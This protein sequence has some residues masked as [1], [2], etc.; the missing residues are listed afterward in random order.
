[1]IRNS[2][3]L[4]LALTFVLT[5]MAFP[6]SVYK[7]PK[8][9]VDQGCVNQGNDRRIGA[10]VICWLQGHL[11]WKSTEKP[12]M[13]ILGDPDGRNL[14]LAWPPYVVYNSPQKDGSWRMFRMGIRYDRTWK[15]YIFP[16]AAAKC[17]DH[18]LTY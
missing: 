2:V 8:K 3:M 7:P 6:C 1:M 4:L 15:G 13:L 16:T 17:L 18:P 9:R 12:D 10:P 5:T 14:G 11:S